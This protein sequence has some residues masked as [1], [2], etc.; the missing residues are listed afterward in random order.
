MSDTFP[1]MICRYNLGQKSL[2]MLVIMSENA[3]SISLSLLNMVFF[4]FP[5]FH[6]EFSVTFKKYFHVVVDLKC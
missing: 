3:H 4:I 5:Y 6:L 1:E 2:A